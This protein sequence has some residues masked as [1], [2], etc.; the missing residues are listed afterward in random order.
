MFV[1]FVDFEKAFDTVWRN[2]LWYKLLIQYINGKMYI[3]IFNLYQ[4]I[5]SNIVYNGCASD[6][7]NCNIGVRQGENLSPL[8]FALYLND[9][10]DFL[11]SQNLSGLKSL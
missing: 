2:G 7:F 5:K 6:Y 4:G 9:L 8:L 11:I 3:P 10:E 1:A